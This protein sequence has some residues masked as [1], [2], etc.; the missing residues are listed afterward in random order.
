M[1][2]ITNKAE[3]RDHLKKRLGSP[4]VSLCDMTDDQL[5]LAIDIAAE[6]FQEFATGMAQVEDV[7]VITTSADVGVYDIDEDITAVVEVIDDCNFGRVGEL[8]TVENALFNA[9]LFSLDSTHGGT[10]EN[11]LTLQMVIEYV[12]FIHTLHG[13]QY[14]IRIDE[15]QHK[16]TLF[17]TPNCNDGKLGFIVTKKID[18]AKLYCLRWVREYAYAIA[19]TQIGLNRSK[20]E[21][22]TLPGGGTLNGA[23]FLQEGKELKEKLDEE[24][25]DRY[26]EPP[27]FFVA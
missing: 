12:D 20:F 8:F 16:A 24:L 3:F 18:E 27:D 25:R 13:K 10:G 1:A 2:T 9:G 19:M 15:I 17:P 21:G 22:V 7:L 26:E 14:D 11:V 23:L 5:D 4:V 6:T